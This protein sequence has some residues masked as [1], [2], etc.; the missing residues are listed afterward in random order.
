[1]SPGLIPTLDSTISIPI[2]RILDVYIGVRNLIFLLDST[3]PI[4]VRGSSIPISEGKSN[5]DPFSYIGV[6]QGP[7]PTCT[8]T[9]I[10]IPHLGRYSKHLLALVCGL[11]P[12]VGLFVIEHAQW[13][14]CL[15]MCFLFE[16]SYRYPQIDM[17]I[18]LWLINLLGAIILGWGYIDGGCWVF[19]FLPG[20]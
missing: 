1:M 5:Q 20:L 2:I 14:Q 15:V 10:Y 18:M 17:H 3:T 13:V 16:T 12:L 4:L 7:A 6:M 11:P 9:C 19:S 8:C